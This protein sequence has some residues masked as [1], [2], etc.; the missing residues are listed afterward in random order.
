MPVPNESDSFSG[1]EE[2][3]SFDGYFELEDLDSDHF[4][5]PAQSVLTGSETSS[6]SRSSSIFEDYSDSEQ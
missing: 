4:H 5:D 6:E 2:S 1:S 3:D